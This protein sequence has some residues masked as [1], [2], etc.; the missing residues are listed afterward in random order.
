MRSINDMLLI[1]CRKNDNISAYDIRRL[2]TPL[3]QVN[4]ART[5][6]DVYNKYGNQR[7]YFDIEPGSG[8]L[9]AGNPA[10]HVIGYDF[11][12]NE[13]KFLFAAHFEG[14]P[15]LSIAPKTESK[16]I[17]FATGSGARTYMTA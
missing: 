1:G 14:V 4:F 2:E 16:Q 11:A 15:A 7:F 6:P 12:S 13:C 3:L 10:G 8:I 9:V 5:G 17:L